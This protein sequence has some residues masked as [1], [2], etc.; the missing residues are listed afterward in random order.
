MHILSKDVQ[1]YVSQIP[2][3]RKP[4]FNQLLEVIR[5]N[6]PT[7]FSEQ[8]SYGMPGWVVSLSR[9]PDGYHCK[10]DT[11]LPFASLASQKNFI[12]LYHMGIYATPDIH[13]WWV[14]EYPKHCKYKLDMGKSCVRFK[15]I[16]DIPLKLV[17]ELFQKMTVQ[18]WI[19]TYEAAL[20]K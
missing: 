19:N 5:E 1:D 13:D 16:E 12:A 10:K 9:Y 2:E 18:Q 7:E 20:K 17:G 15:K 8:L 4:I 3:E 11:P 6:I 14:E